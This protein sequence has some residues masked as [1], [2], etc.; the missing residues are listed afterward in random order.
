[1]KFLALVVTLALASPLAAQSAPDVHTSHDQSVHSLHP[2]QHGPGH[3]D[4]KRQGAEPGDA[5]AQHKM[6][7]SCCR[8]AAD[9]K[10]M[11]CCQKMKAAGKKPCCE[12]KQA[13]PKATE[14]KH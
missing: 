8:K 9:G 4:H 1:M 14:H 13:D 10:M 6:D 7:E 2:G 11:E 5:H 3:A 12:G